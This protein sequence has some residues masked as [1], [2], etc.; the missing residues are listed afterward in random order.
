MRSHLLRPSSP[1]S[2]SIHAYLR[3]VRHA[4]FEG[5][6]MPLGI[7]GDGH[8]RLVFIDGEVPVPPY[9][10]WSQSDIALG[11]IAGPLRGLHDAAPGFDA[12]RS[13]LE[14]QSR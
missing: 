3:A 7:D 11:S 13:Q 12:Q 6:P 9:P 10:D 1:Y 5:A 4:G 14:P 8:E 2:G